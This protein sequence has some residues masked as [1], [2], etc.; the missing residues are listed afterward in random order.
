EVPAEVAEKIV[1]RARQVR[2][3]FDFNALS[4]GLVAR[5]HE[6][7]GARAELHHERI[8]GFCLRLIEKAAARDREAQVRKWRTA[9]LERLAG[10]G[11]Q[12][13]SRPRLLLQKMVQGCEGA[14]LDHGVFPRRAP[15]RADQL[16][17]CIPASNQPE[18]PFTGLRMCQISSNGSAG[19][20][21]SS[22]I[23]PENRTLA[24]CSSPS[25]T[26]SRS[27]AFRVTTS[28]CCAPECP[29]ASS[30]SVL[31]MSSVV[32]WRSRARSPRSFACC[33][34][35]KLRRASF[36]KASTSKSAGM[37]ETNWLR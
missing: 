2:R 14:A 4:G 37:L 7:Q 6:G 15:L 24:Q 36:K 31:N 12:A 32:T 21:A 3:T 25:V 13:L 27:A 30:F 20:L 23:E 9:K 8:R 34:R 11:S 16:G 26:T 22:R 17:C 28:V 1:H 19:A 18:E 29:A 5:K 35:W 10:K 33:R